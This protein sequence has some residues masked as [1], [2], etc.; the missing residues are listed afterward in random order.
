MVINAGKHCGSVS[1]RRI[2]HT[3]SNLHRR[4]PCTLRRTPALG[5]LPATIASSSSTSSTTAS[6]LT[7]TSPS[8]STTTAGTVVVVVAGVGVGVVWVLVRAEERQVEVGC[9]W[10]GQVQIAN[11]LD[12]WRVGGWRR[13]RVEP[14][15][16]AVCLLFSMTP[17]RRCRW[18]S[19]F[20]ASAGHH[21]SN[22]SAA[23]T[24]APWHAVHR[25]SVLTIG[26]V[27][28]TRGRHWQTI[29]NV[30]P[31][32]RPFA[33]KSNTGTEPVMKCWSRS[34]ISTQVLS[35]KPEPTLLPC[36]S[37]EP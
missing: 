37:T 36:S 2:P 3:V 4:L 25:R 5:R 11:P 9:R 23:G 35:P 27:L 22:F 32:L 6:L 15:T 12:L 29:H 17:A 18:S 10:E 16:A 20:A 14:I 28:P 30:S 33:S 24:V 1:H 26:P 19:S 7:P 21:S 31:L 13:E 34:S 8:S